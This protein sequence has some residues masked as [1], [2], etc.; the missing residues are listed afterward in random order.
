MGRDMGAL[1]ASDGVPAWLAGRYG[2]LELKMNLRPFSLMLLLSTG[3]SWREAGLG[4]DAALK[5]ASMVS[6]V[7]ERASVTTGLVRFFGLR[8]VGSQ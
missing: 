7:N 5:Y 1:N 3:F 2:D 6:V 4:P 8:Q